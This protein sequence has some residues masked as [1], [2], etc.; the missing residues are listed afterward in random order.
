MSLRLSGA[1]RADL[2]WALNYLLRFTPLPPLNS[3]P[4]FPPLLLYIYLTHTL[5]TFPF[6]T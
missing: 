4:S 2:I 3:P 6:S 1:M 5:P